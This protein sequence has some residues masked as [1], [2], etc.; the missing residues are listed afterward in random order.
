[1]PSLPVD[2]RREAGRSIPAFI[3]VPV[4]ILAM[5][6]AGVL[7]VHSRIDAWD[8]RQ[9][10][11][12]VEHRTAWLNRTTEWTTQLAETIPVLVI[13]LI[14][15]VAARRWT[16]GWRTTVFLALAVGGEKLIYFVSSLLVRRD[17][18]PVPPLGSTY[19]TSSFPS[20]HV[21]SA[22]TLYGAI[23]LAVG[24][25]LGRKYLVALISVMVAFTLIVAFSRMYRGFHYPSDCIAG[26]LVGGVWLTI[27]LRVM[28]PLSE[29]H[30]ASPAIVEPISGADGMPASAIS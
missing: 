2:L 12:L 6:G 18:P 24:A 25:W 10:M 27:A 28:S 30:R 23:A 11:W 19:A 20:G 13:L 16:H 5:W 14:A 29:S 8:L 15:M 4:L 7:I 9:N 3:A 17:R 21:G 1:V 22:I 26:A